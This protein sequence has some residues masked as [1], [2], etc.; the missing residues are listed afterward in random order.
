LHTSTGNQTLSKKKPIAT[1]RTIAEI[2]GANK[3]YQIPVYQRPYVWTAQNVREL[4]DDMV[5]QK[6]AKEFL[7]LGGI[8][9]CPSINNIGPITANIDMEWYDVIDGQQ[10]LTTIQIIFCA[11]AKLLHGENGVIGN[12]IWY[13]ASD[14]NGT[15]FN[16][17]R[18]FSERD[19]TKLFLDLLR[20]HTHT[21][22]AQRK[23]TDDNETP[24]V[25]AIRLAYWAARN[26][27]TSLFK[28]HQTGD[29]DRSALRSFGNY[30]TTHA[31][32]VEV[33]STN[34]LDAARTFEK[35]NNRG[36]RLEQI[37]LL[38]TRF[39]AG[40]RN[41]HLFSKRWDSLIES[42]PEG[43]GDNFLRY[44]LA[45]VTDDLKPAKRIFE[46]FLEEVQNR[47]DLSFDSKDGL[48]DRLITMAKHYKNFVQYKGPNERN[49]E[50]LQMLAASG[51]KRRQHALL[52]MAGVHLES[53][54]PTLFDIYADEVEKL[55]FVS[56]TAGIL[57]NEDERQH[58]DICKRIKAVRN[59]QELEE[60]LDQTTRQRRVELAGRFREG[61]L[62]RSKVDGKVERDR[63]FTE[64]GAYVVRRIVKYIQEVKDSTTLP[65]SEVRKNDVE[66]IWPLSNAAA[67]GDLAY[68]LGNIILLAPGGNRAAGNNPL[69]N[70]AG[71]DTKIP[72][73]QGGPALA[74][75]LVGARA[76]CQTTKKEMLD[77]LSVV[78]S[79]TTWNANTIE[80]LRNAYLTLAERIWIK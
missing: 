15:D 73:Y 19:E 42:L 43:H 32:C 64:T 65:F 44:Y 38:K 28:N 75:I 66:H 49:I 37:D 10:R 30:L 50:A 45:Y 31:T 24:E 46:I 59:R 71:G 5:E 6:E 57:P 13:K 17:P 51:G 72:H 11:I 39:L 1:V 34:A 7:D 69:F 26:H 33:L 25:R 62:D 76:S 2:F 80:D 54:D 16:V 36:V 12:C 4:I 53:I 67:I 20:Q 68:D 27:L 3:A 22:P 14:D 79:V 52:L 21:D 74:Q 70:P 29:L 78:P 47:P 63:G 58:L 35:T 60:A 8:S 23:N 55:L 56:T 61:V 48:L 77:I 41:D 9:I 40:H 18:L